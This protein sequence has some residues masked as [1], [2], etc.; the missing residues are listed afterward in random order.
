[1][2]DLLN[3]MYDGACMIFFGLKLWLVKFLERGGG[4]QIKVGLFLE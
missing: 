4:L 3:S 1:M 2:K